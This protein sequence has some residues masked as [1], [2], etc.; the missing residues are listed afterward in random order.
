MFDASFG[1]FRE[2]FGTAQFM[3]LSGIFCNGQI[4]EMWPLEAAL[5]H[6]LHLGSTFGHCSDIFPPSGLFGQLFVQVVSPLLGREGMIQ[7]EKNGVAKVAA[8]QEIC[9]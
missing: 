7:L 4:S 9:S 5:S 3:G 2:A 6:S 8:Q 1:T